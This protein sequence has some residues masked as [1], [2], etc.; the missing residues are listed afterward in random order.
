MLKFCGESF[1][2]VNIH[3]SGLVGPCL[4]KVWH[5]KGFMGN[6]NTN[7]LTEL[8][9]NEWIQEFRRTIFDQSFNHCN[10]DQCGKFWNLDQLVSLDHIDPLPV[11]PTNIHLHLDENCNLKCASCRNS[12]IYSKEVNPRAAKI[13]DVLADDYKDF[14]KKVFVYG[15]GTGDIFASSAYQQFLRSDRVPKCWNFCF[16]TNGNLITKNLDLIDQIST[17]I[18]LVIVSLD[19]ATANTYRDIRGGVFEIVLDGIRELV[20]RGIKVSTQYVVQYKNYQEVREYVDLCK[21]IGVRHI[22]LQKIDRWGHLNNSWWQA[23]QIDRN[24][25]VDY[26][27]LIKA[28]TDFKQDPQIGLCGGLEQLLSRVC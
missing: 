4:C 8:F 19:A 11:L 27:F 10:P 16:T 17:Q 12:N 3:E 7:T 2:T 6:L 25:N 9:S 20:A 26:D 1:D 14:D 24:P 13:L 23:N 18:D 15:D 21:S 28:L 5:T 22:G